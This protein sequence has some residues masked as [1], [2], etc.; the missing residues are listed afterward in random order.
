MQPRATASR[1]P[2][3]P[4]ATTLRELG[5]SEYEAKSYAALAARQPATAYEIAKVTG[6]PRANVY[7]ALR[8]LEA[9][10]AVQPVTEH[11][12]RYVPV[13]PEQF[14]RR[15]QRNTA[16]LCEDVVRAIKRDTKAEESAYV[17]LYRGAN[18]VRDKFTELIEGARDHVWIKAPAA[19]IEPYRDALVKAACRG[20]TIR[21]VA[22]G[23]NLA[24]LRAH[25]GIKV[26][27]HEGDG[28]PHGAADFLLTATF[29]SHG[30]MIVTHTDKVVG[31][32]ARDQSIIYVIETLLLHEIYFAEIYAALGPQ[33]EARFG[34]RL[35]KLRRKYR[36]A[37]RERPVMDGE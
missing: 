9:K 28:Q 37:G 32:Y 16:G 26:F 36:P 27:P 8:N 24:A 6:L 14:F 7:G 33:L 12:V 18:D 5:F 19:L 29:D 4:L 10:G 15:L 11:P 22:F 30:T 31:S 20:V 21:I 13:D 25:R 3:Q 2:A 35:D 1:S 23:E 34:K 17:W